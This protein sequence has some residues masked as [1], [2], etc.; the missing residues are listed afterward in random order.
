[1]NP[2]NAVGAV[3]HETKDVGGYRYVYQDSDERLTPLSY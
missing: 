1:M 2:G 3:L